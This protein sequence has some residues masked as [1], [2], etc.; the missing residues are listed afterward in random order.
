MD[1]VGRSPGEGAG[2]RAHRLKVGAERDL[3]LAFEHVEGVRVMVVDVRVGTLL[4]GLV[5]EPGHD[6]V[7]ELGEDPQRPLRPVGDDLALAGR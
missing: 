2:S 7:V 4:A 1:D 3:D 5:A 6:H